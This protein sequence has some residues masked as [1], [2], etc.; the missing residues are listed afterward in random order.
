MILLFCIYVASVHLLPRHD[1]EPALYIAPIPTEKL[2]C[3][4]LLRI[5]YSKERHASPVNMKIPSRGYSGGYFKRV[6]IL[7]ML[8]SC[9]KVSFCRQRYG[10]KRRM[11]N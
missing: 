5:A 2:R 8:L 7:F 6:D 3:V 11:K 10:K 4:P 1:G 9:I